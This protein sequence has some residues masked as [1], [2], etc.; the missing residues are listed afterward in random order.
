MKKFSSYPF[1]RWALAMLF[2]WPF[3]LLAQDDALAPVSRTY[4]LTN[5]TIIQAP[6]RKISA[7]T[8]V[9]KN[10][11]IQSVGKGTAIPPEAIIIKADS[12]FVYAGF[13]DGLSRTGVNKPKDDVSKERPKDPGNP[14]PERA[15]IT[16]Q[17]DVRPYLNPSEKSLEEMRGIG[18]TAAHVVPYGGMLPGNGSIIS[19]GG[20]SADAMIIS[21]K[22]SFYSELTPAERAY[23][24]TVMGVMA[25]YRDLYRQAT[26]T[27]N[28]QALYA[29][30]RAGLER[31]SSDR[32]LESFYPVI[33]KRQPVFFKA[34]KVLELQR[35][36]IL[37]KE[38]GFTLTLI[39]VKEGWDMISKVKASNAQVFLSLDLPEEKKDEKKTDEKKA[40]S[41]K[42]A[43]KPKSA[44][45]IEKEVLEKRRTDF[46]SKYVGQASA[47]QKAGVKFGFSTLTAKSKDIPANLRRMIK[48]G[49][50]EDAALA[51]LTTTPAEIFGLSDRLG[52][53]DNGKI[54]NLVI[55]DKPYFNEKAKVRYVFVDGVLYKHEV[56]EA[57][58]A[59]AN[60][61]VEIEGTWSV[62]T[63]T[64][65]G[66]AQS[67]LIIKKEGTVYSGEIKIAGSQLPQPEK[68]TSIVL[69]GNVLKIAYSI[70]IDGKN[71]DVK[72][73]VIIDGMTFKGNTTVASET[74]PVEGKKDPKF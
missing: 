41:V 8:I 19:L 73:D 34:E 30:N 37:Q 20:S 40:D 51:S 52:T 44:A 1:K 43:E 47:Y 67:T 5:A 50:S 33:D 56:S 35:V 25:K 6:G 15:G 42:R 9:I 18:F 46:I 69:E 16:P 11:L 58:K 64:P 32:I 4:A 13:I 31:P 65:Q 39:E 24:T 29:S 17:N 57:K 36:L 12:L 22:N 62:T 54:A 3:A 60:A 7:A 10:G 23:P 45:D 74:F 59:D 61:K 21:H 70:S 55:S 66:T 53:V 27:K 72:M 14:T 71:M 38:L 28:Y 49:L 48:A 68:L 26:L 63:V 2:C